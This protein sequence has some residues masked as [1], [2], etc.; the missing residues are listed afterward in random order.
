M[1]ISIES[2]FNTSCRNSIE[3]LPE[4][5]VIPIV[6]YDKPSSS[7]MSIRYE[8]GSCTTTGRAFLR[9]PNESGLRSSLF[10]NSRVRFFHYV[11]YSR[12]TTIIARCYTSNPVT[13]NWPNV[14]NHIDGKLHFTSLVS[15][16][17]RKATL[18]LFV[19]CW[20]LTSVCGLCIRKVFRKF[21]RKREVTRFV[22]CG[23]ARFA[24][25][26]YQ[27]SAVVL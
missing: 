9:L 19:V 5:A 13:Q 22:Y 6:L 2:E 14:A 3:T 21:W 27:K 4:V 18:E 17:T 23:F 10:R 26:V 1:T 15:K 7:F 11:R 12:V 8:Y 20:L 16:A 25:S 24:R